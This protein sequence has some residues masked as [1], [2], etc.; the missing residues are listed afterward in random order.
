MPDHRLISTRF[1]NSG[2]YVDLSNK[3]K[4]LYIYMFTN[5][6]DCGFVDNVKNWIIL[7]DDKDSNALE[8]LNND[9]KSAL[10]ELGNKG[11]IYQFINKYEHRVYLIRHWFIHN[12]WKKGLSTNYGKYRAMVELSNGEYCW[13]EE[14]SKEDNIKQNK[15][16]QNK[17]NQN[18]D[19]YSWNELLNDI[20]SEKEEDGV[21]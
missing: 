21:N 3:A 12:K 13:R 10:E 20:E 2:Q 17:V 18:K 9:Y 15:V 16:N 19:D 8:L 14:S 1:I 7:L 5:A 11:L 6:D 4:L